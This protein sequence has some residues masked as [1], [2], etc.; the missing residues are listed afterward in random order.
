MKTIRLASGSGYWGDALDPAVEVCEKGNIDY[1]GFDHLAEL[2]MSILHKMKAKDPNKGYIPD[3]VPWM[4]KLLPICQKNNIK[5]VTN[6]GGANPEA[7]ADAVIELAKK[8]GIK[9]LKIGVVTGDDMTD[10]LPEIRAKGHKLT[11]MDTGEED[12]DRIQDRI[13]GAYAYTGAEGII[14]ALKQGCNLVITGRV[15]DNAVYV[16]PMMYEFGWDFSEKYEKQ[17]GA[18]V[19]V[20]HIIECSGSCT[21]GISGQWKIAPELW[22]IGFPIAEV[23]E[24]GDAVITKVEGSGGIV[25]EWTIKEHMVYEVID[26]NNYLM[27]DAI[28]DFTAPKLEDLGN[29]RVRITNMTGKGRPEMIKVCL[30]Y[31][32]GFIGEAFLITPWPDAYEKAKKLEEIMRGRLDVIGVKPDELRFNYVGVNTLHGTTAPEPCYDMNEVGVRI[33][34]KTKTR[35][36]A[37]AIRRE[38]THLWT[39]GPVGTAMGTPYQ[40]RKIISLWPTLVPREFIT[41]KV[42]IK[43]VK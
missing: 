35:D 42:T 3:L 40:P 4:E 22:K 28:A 27:P 10:K 36:E 1:L 37:D 18:A 41:Q 2:S 26:P 16:G 33:I 13:L 6:A 43:E 11:N 39:F 20:G 14:D 29:N 17:V 38:G 19:T 31:D 12:I 9:G 8:L 5:M 25:N 30:G 24:N 23:S 32:D 15:S 21:G 7:A 34:A